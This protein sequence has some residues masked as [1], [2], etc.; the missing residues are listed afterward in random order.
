MTVTAV[1]LFSGCGG[2]DLGVRNAGVQVVW[3]NDVDPY[4]AATYTKYFPE[5]E[6][7]RGDIR[8][9][10]REELPTADLLIGCYPCTGFSAGAWRRWRDGGERNLFENPKN[11]LFVEFVKA[12]PAVQPKF[13]FIENVP[14]MKSSVDGWFYQA[15]KEML[16]LVGYDVFHGQR[17][18][19]DYGVPQDRR[20]IFIVGVRRDID[21]EYTFPTPSHGPGRPHPYQK[22]I[23]AI[24]GLPMWPIGEFEDVRYHGHYLTRNR[25]RDWHEVSYTIVANSHHVTLHPMG[26]SMKKVGKDHWALQ[27]SFNRR[28]SW[29][30]CA[31]LQS[32]PV[33]FEP[34]GSL[35]AKYWQI[36]NAVPPLMSQALVEPVVRFLNE[37]SEVPSFCF[38]DA[39]AS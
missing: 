13:V 1:S 37:S 2:F 27:G 18:A 7:R 10:N 32:F 6:F 14:G 23:D 33:D 35:T 8:K 17:N 15:Q 34:Q 31:L 30:E 3:A 39:L 16:D 12:V 36:G 19:K 26:E 4:A 28:L 9:M 25:K 5:T 21:Y 11:F 38:E 20:R 29:Y 24:L 22:Q